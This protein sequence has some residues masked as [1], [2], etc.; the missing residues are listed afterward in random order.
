MAFI[1]WRDH[2]L[3]DGMVYRFAQALHGVRGHWTRSGLS[4]PPN[5]ILAR[6]HH[7]HYRHC[8][9]ELRLACRGDIHDHGVD[10]SVFFSQW[11]R[12]AMADDAR[13]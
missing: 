4:T 2:S 12:Q 10:P 3:P 1:D 6:I 13:R 5:T 7:A 8:R 9:L 11:Y